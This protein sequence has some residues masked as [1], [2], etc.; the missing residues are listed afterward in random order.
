M[1]NLVNLKDFDARF[2]K[3]TEHLKTLNTRFFAG[4]D[5]FGVW[6][7]SQYEQLQLLAQALVEL[8]HAVG[9]LVAN[10]RVDNETTPPKSPPA[11]ARRGP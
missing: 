7:T 9:I 8:R 4:Q 11:T 1:A 5:M 2:E 3:C 10:N 6:S